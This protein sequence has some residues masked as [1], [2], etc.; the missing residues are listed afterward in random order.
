GIPQSGSSTRSGKDDFFLEPGGIICKVPADLRR[1][2]KFDK[3]VLV[4]SEPILQTAIRQQ[5][6]VIDSWTGIAPR[7][8]HAAAAVK[9][10]PEGDGSVIVRHREN[11]LLDLIFIDFEMVLRQACDKAVASVGHRNVYQDHVDIGANGWN[12][13]PT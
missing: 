5:L 2:G 13:R 10:D 7:Y 6:G 1:T 4:I 3:K 8:T 9:D 11:V 12:R